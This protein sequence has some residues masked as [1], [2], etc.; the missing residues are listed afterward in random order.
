VH[1]PDC[2]EQHQTANPCKHRKCGPHR[3]APRSTAFAGA[4]C[5]WVAF[6][7]QS[8]PKLGWGAGHGLKGGQGRV[9]PRLDA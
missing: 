3:A 1:K 8:P 6:G 7:W 5:G 2:T 4:A 9:A